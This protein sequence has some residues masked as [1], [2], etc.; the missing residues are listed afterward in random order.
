MIVDI[1][2]EVDINHNACQIM[3]TLYMKVFCE[4]LNFLSIKFAKISENKSLCK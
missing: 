1:F 2:E 4:M 3:K